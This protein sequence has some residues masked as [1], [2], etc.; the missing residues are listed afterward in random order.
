MSSTWIARNAIYCAAIAAI[1][2]MA[3]PAPGL[4]QADCRDW[5]TPGFFKTATAGDLRRCLSAGADIEARVGGLRLRPLH[6]AARNGNVELVTALLEAGADLAGG[7][8][9][10]GFTP[11]HFA[12]ESG[13]AD[14]VTV[15]LAAGADFEAFSE[16]GRLTPLHMAAGYGTAEAAAVLVE[17]GAGLE[18]RSGKCATAL[19]VAAALG[20]AETVV[21]LLDA[22][23]NPKAR[24]KARE[25][26]FDL[27]K[28]AG[29]PPNSEAYRRLKYGR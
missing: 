25:T 28:K 3:A 12:A 13:S 21:M 14:T 1:V 18:V 20:N 2:W 7:N 8:H 9:D 16:K 23:A 15:L 5:K 6:L 11:L 10:D 26:P 24:I 22:G 19:H 17:A 27:A 4:A 29:L